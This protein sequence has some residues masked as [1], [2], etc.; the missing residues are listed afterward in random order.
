MREIQE[1]RE[2]QEIAKMIDVRDL[3][4]LWYSGG[5]ITHVGDCKGE[6]GSL[7]D[8]R[9]FCPGGQISK[10][11]MGCIHLPVPFVNVQYMTPKN[12]VLQNLLGISFPELQMMALRN[13]RT[14]VELDQNTGKWKFV[15]LHG[16]I[17]NAA[18]ENHP[19]RRKL[20]GIDAIELL[21]NGSEYKDRIILH[22]LPVLP[23]CERM[24]DPYYDPKRKQDVQYL[25]ENVL[26]KK[27]A[28][29][30]AVKR[31]V[32]SAYG[33][34]SREHADTL[35]T[36]EDKRFQLQKAVGNLINNGWN[37]DPIRDKY[38]IPY[39]SLEEYTAQDPPHWNEFLEEK[40]K[41]IRN[42]QKDAFGSTVSEKTVY[43][44]DDIVY[45]MI[46]DVYETYFP[47]VAGFHKENLFSAGFAAVRKG[48]K[49]FFMGYEEI[50]AFVAAIYRSMEFYH[51][52]MIV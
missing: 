46:N 22:N 28:Y 14:I 44:M 52:K 7:W 2:I 3:E 23:I 9:V 17:V 16:G 40:A 4:I 21:L 32:E 8:K 10:T 30:K 34:K 50:P 11:N 33:G 49:E 45:K 19:T 37:G 1:T 31:E 12:P 47:E 25:Y 24:L 18:T 38:G 39:N 48:R 5:E 26:R 29:K 51:R 41:M 42:M 13:E 15:G 36:L 6:P 35:R 20:Y 43:Y 27:N